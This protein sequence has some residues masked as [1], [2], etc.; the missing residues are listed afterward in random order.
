VVD[1]VEVELDGGQERA[2]EA[3]RVLAGRQG[4]AVSVKVVVA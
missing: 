2:A 4:A 1:D 3:D